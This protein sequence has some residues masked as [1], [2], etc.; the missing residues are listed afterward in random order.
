M[1]ESVYPERRLALR[2]LP[3]WD[4]VNT[5][6]R[7]AEWQL[8]DS[9]D[10]RGD[11]HYK[12]TVT[13]GVSPELWVTYIEDRITDVSVLV[14]F[15]SDRAAVDAL[16]DRLSLLV[17]TSSREEVLEPFGDDLTRQDV[18]RGLVRLALCAPEEFDPGI[19]ARIDAASRNGDPQIR[20]AAAWS[21]IYLSWPQAGSLLRRMAAE[22]PD[23]SV[24]AGAQGLLDTADRA[25]AATDAEKPVPPLKGDA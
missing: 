21:T 14:V 2:Q 16:A 12:R 15:G 5:V 7:T 23:P 24:R 6:A 13:W 22:D 25:R 3:G 20:N 18:A 4:P 1:A 8:V 9:N 11:E 19:F 17:A 10:G